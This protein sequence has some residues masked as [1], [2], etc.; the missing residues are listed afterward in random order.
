M[1]VLFDNNDTDK[2]NDYSSDNSIPDNITCLKIALSR[3]I[4]KKMKSLDCIAGQQQKKRSNHVDGPLPLDSRTCYKKIL[5]IRLKISCISVGVR[6]TS[7]PE[8]VKHQKIK[9]WGW[10]ALLYLDILN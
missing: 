1:N 4:W 7:I 3:L 2:E 5:D 6:C 9:K 10:S 8:Q